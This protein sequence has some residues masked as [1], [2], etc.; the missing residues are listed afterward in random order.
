[1]ECAR[2]ADHT[3]C[4]RRSFGNINS[5]VTTRQSLIAPL[6]PGRCESHA[7][8][9]RRTN[10]RTALAKPSS[11][12]LS[13]TALACSFTSSLALP[14]AMEKPLLRNIKDVVRHVA[15]GGDLLR[16][17]IQKLRQS[18][19]DRALVGLRMRHIEIVG[20]RARRARLVARAPSAPA[21]SQAATRSR[22]SE[23]PTILTACARCA[24]VK[25]GTTLASN[26]TVQASRATCGASLSR[27][28]HSVFGIDP[29]VQPLVEDQLQ[30]LLGRR[31]IERMALDH[32]QVGIDKNAAVEAGDGALSAR[33][34]RSACSCRAVAGRW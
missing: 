2:A 33:A 13:V 27:I 24:S 14:M 11:S 6:P 16:R 23:T 26:F 7:A 20:L 17:N 18:R 30:G 12:L 21:F 5:V 32:G 31:G 22:S 25:D 28:S 29:G 1:M 15:D 10:F 34:A 4:R 19:H 9:A 3:R 8:A